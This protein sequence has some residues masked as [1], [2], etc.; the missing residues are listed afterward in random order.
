MATGGDPG[1]ERAVVRAQARAALTIKG[2]CD[3]Y[4]DATDKGLVLTKIGRP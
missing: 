3:L 2:L 4:L 1:T